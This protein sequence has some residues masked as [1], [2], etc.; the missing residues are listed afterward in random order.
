MKILLKNSII[1]AAVVAFLGFSMVT[2]WA[3]KEKEGNG[4]YVS[5]N[6]VVIAPRERIAT[7][8]VENNSK[9]ARRY[10]V[11][12]VN[13]KMGE[14][15]TTGRVENFEFE[16][17]K[18]LK[19]VPRRFTLEPGER[20]VVRIMA[21]RPADL[22]DGDYHSH[23]LFRQVPLA[24]DGAPAAGDTA[25]ITADKKNFS[26]EITTRYGMAVPVIVQQGKLESAMKL[27]DVKL[28]E[29]G[30][31]GKA[32]SISFLRSGNAESYAELTA[33]YTPAGAGE[34]VPV[35]TKQIVRMYRE[36]D[37]VTKSFVLAPPKDVSIAKKGVLTIKL[38]RPA[39]E[40]KGENEIVDTRT[41]DVF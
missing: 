38:M 35:L 33:D 31:G 18:M 25:N 4:L 8:T 16:A 7:L 40:G 30:K 17:K 28:V 32:L 23:T 24:E 21:R 11:S 14:N 1:G 39:S 13:N 20:Q 15:G 36:V 27:E 12:V 6:R 26:L 10:D 2:V 37:R 22:A 3:E 29:A 34:A 5:P 19:Y 9:I 41:V